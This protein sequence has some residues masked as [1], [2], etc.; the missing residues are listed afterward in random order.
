MASKVLNGGL[1]RR[2]AFRDMV[3]T[4]ACC[5]FFLTDAYYSVGSREFFQM[6]LI[7][8]GCVSAY[9]N[10]CQK[11]GVDLFDMNS[12]LDVYRKKE[13]RTN[14]SASILIIKMILLPQVEIST[15][16]PQIPAG[17]KQLDRAVNK[18]G[19]NIEPMSLTA[20]PSLYFAENHQW[21]IDLAK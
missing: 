6:N 13:N 3:F 18:V 7:L 15:F 14:F 12:V 8:Q 21:W 9:Y 16:D 4:E 5:F 20:I 10:E 1:W 2:I 17:L 19:V 11:F